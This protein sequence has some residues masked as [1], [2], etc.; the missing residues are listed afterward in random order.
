M[1]ALVLSVNAQAG[2]FRSTYTEY[3]TPKGSQFRVNYVWNT[4]TGKGIRY[5][6]SDEKTW[7][8]SK[9][10]LPALPLGPTTG[11]I[12]EV[13]CKA[14]EYFSPSGDQF[15][16]LYYW[17]TKTGKAVRYYY[18]DDEKWEASKAELPVNPFGEATSKVG[19]VMIE[20]TEYFSPDKD[21]FRILIYT[22]SVTGKVV[23]YYYSDAQKWEKSDAVFPIISID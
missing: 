17:N 15:R 11:E 22:N 18:S 14:I 6:Y 7:E 21:N 8:K 19:E 23:R 9:A 20:A 2:K 1:L 12:G 3:F 4:K 13:M 10:E 5:Y 16:A